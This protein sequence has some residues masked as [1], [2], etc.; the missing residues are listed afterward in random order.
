[1]N[2]WYVGVALLGGGSL[3]LIGFDY[4]RGGHWFDIATDAP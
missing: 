3:A 1:M 2:L 4:I